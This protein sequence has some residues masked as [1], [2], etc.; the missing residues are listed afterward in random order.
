MRT[1]P[2]LCAALCATLLAAACGHALASGPYLFSHAPEDVRLDTC[3]LLANGGQLPGAT[4]TVIGEEVRLGFELFG[5]AQPIPMV[6]RFKAPPPLFDAS[7]SGA[8]DAFA[9]YGSILDAELTVDGA[10]CTVPFGQ[11]E[12]EAMVAP[13]HDAF[14]GELVIHYALASNQD[15]RCPDSCDLRVRY[16]AK[17]AR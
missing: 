12:L 17:R 3:G 5:P 16:S 15:S 9:A 14:D 2:T 7:E 6:G 4:L 11:V 1:S 13:S 8:R 10:V